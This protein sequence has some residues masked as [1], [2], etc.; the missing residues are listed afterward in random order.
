MQDS[1]RFVRFGLDVKQWEANRP[2]VDAA[3]PSGCG[4]CGAASR[5]A[6]E[7]LTLHGHGLRLRLLY[8]LLAAGQAPGTHEV[9]LR[10]YRCVRCGAITT[11]GP[12]GLL[13]GHLYGVGTILV[14]LWLWAMLGWPAAEVRDAL[15]PW[16]HSGLG[17]AGRWA[18]LG[19]WARELP[20]PSTL[21]LPPAL[22]LRGMARRRVQVALSYAPTGPPDMAG[23]MAGAAHVA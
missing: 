15:R 14:A 11:V 22:S 13:R 21:R 6:G 8:G 16:G 20:W 12:R 3:R 10:R 17:C 9:W 18:S 1:P 7:N 4:Q 5:A 19:R 2:S 23:V